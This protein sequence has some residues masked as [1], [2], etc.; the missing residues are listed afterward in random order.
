[1]LDS[2]EEG[3][4]DED[5]AQGKISIKTEKRKKEKGDKR[6]RDGP[7]KTLRNDSYD[8]MNES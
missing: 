6:Q 1:M 4:F 3:P 2:R 8:E 5:D 7:S